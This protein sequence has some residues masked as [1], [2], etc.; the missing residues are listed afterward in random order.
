MYEK[1]IKDKGFDLTRELA[2]EVIHGLVKQESK[3]LEL[4]ERKDLVKE[5]YKLRDNIK[6]IIKSGTVGDRKEDQLQEELTDEDKTL[7]NQFINSTNKTIQELYTYPFTRP[8]IAKALSKIKY[9]GDE[10]GLDGKK[11]VT[12]WDK[13]RDMMYK[14]LGI[15]KPTII[16]NINEILNFSLTSPELNI[17]ERTVQSDI[18]IKPESVKT[19]KINKDAPINSN[20]NENRPTSDKR[21]NFSKQNKPSSKINKNSLIL[22]NKNDYKIVNSLKF[23]E[24]NNNNLDHSLKDN[25]EYFKKCH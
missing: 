9:Q 20:S 8:N 23:I 17:S 19:K 18:K 24:F 4:P 15:T 7:L 14:L 6:E 11:I 21:S 12:V 2:H 13:L 25:I 1:T 22:D 3:K 5:S 10:T 16:D